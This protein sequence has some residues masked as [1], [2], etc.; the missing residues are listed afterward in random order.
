MALTTRLASI[1][2]VS[3]LAAGCNQSLFDANLGDDGTGDGGTSIPD[4]RNDE[5]DSGGDG[6]RD[7][8]GDERDGAP[9]ARV[10]DAGPLPEP[11]Y[12][13]IYE[14]MDGPQ[15]FP[16]QSGT[17]N[18]LSAW[19]SLGPDSQV[20][21]AIVDCPAHP[22]SEYCMGLPV[23]ALLF[24]STNDTYRPALSWIAP[25]PRVVVNFQWLVRVSALRTLPASVRILQNDTVIYTETAELLDQTGGNLIRVE[26]T[27]GDVLQVIPAAGDPAGGHIGMSMEFS[28]QSTLAGSPR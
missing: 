13:E 18:G 2:L 12:V 20:R 15:V 9:D 8:G 23:N 27:V 5:R 7:G 28:E 6:R 19:V 3:A 10:V 16:M 14:D 17:W 11:E 21:S 22:G 1:L 26:V 24:V 25:I 4:A